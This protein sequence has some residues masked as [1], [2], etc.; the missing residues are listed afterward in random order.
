MGA[1]GAGKTTIGRALAAALGWPF[2]DA[3]DLHSTQS[4]EKMRAGVPLD[5]RD[6]AAWIAGVHAAIARALDRREHAVVACSALKERHRQALRDGLRPVRFVYLKATAGLLRQR[7]LGR[8][9]HFAG[10]ALVASQ[11]ADLEE[12]HDDVT[13]TVDATA[14]AERILGAIREQF[15]V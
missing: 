11:L 10:P 1:A 13:L 7:L 14:P 2:V 6:R 15:G 8:R 12:P 5:E 3:D 4:I 9:G